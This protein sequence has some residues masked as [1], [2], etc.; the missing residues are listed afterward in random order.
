MGTDGKG[1]C[2]F[3]GAIDPEGEDDTNVGCVDID[4][5]IDGTSEGLVLLAI[6]GNCEGLDDDD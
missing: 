5:S 3:D 2:L 6:V 4:G 1:D